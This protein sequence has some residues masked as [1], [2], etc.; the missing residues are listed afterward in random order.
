MAL[1]LVA[2]AQAGKGTVNHDKSDLKLLLTDIA[3]VSIEQVA[4]LSSQNTLPEPVLD[5]DRLPSSAST[6]APVPNYRQN[7][8]ATIRPSAPAYSSDDPWNTNSRF[9]SVPISTSEF[10]GSR[11]TS[12]NGAPSNLAGSGLPKDWWKRQE[13]VNVTILGQQGFI[14]NRYTVYQLSTDV[15]LFY[16]L[17]FKSSMFTKAGYSS[18]QTIFRVCFSVGLPNTTVSLPS[19]P[20]FTS[21]T[22]W[23]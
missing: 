17:K 2:L 20:C 4:A 11:A 19:V 22:N 9:P 14:L 21:K 16:K 18:H 8:G 15:G 6:F 1:A 3:D 23:R 13:S 10:D 12:T 5:L 7:S